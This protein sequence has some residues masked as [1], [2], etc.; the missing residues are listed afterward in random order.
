M[1]RLLI[2]CLVMTSCATITQVGQ[3]RRV[4]N[5]DMQVDRLGRVY[6]V[7]SDNSV[8]LSGATLQTSYLYAD[9]R[10]GLI[11]HVDVTNPMKILVFYPAYR[12]IVVLDNTLSEV[13]RIELDEALYEDVQAV[14]M[15][16]D[17]NIWIYD[18]A[19]YQLIKVDEVGREVESSINLVEL[20][21]A[22]LSPSAIKEV[23]NLVYIADPDLGVV[24]FDNFAQYIKLLPIKGV[25]AVHAD[26]RQVY[27]LEGPK[28]YRY[29]D[30][31]FAEPLEEVR[32]D[33]DPPFIKA[34]PAS[35]RSY[36][37]LYPDTIRQVS[38]NQ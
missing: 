31:I 7:R 23:A 38:V 8:T 18:K 33:N 21:L 24:V 3:Q 13:S 12:R 34:L 30:D 5:T 14:A 16:N 37:L 19:R 29:K 26:E 15:A 11:S 28:L 27:F 9:N 6:T 4:V 22:D 20:S 35:D 2:I 32:L 10:L 36:Y 1:G 25:T 17:N